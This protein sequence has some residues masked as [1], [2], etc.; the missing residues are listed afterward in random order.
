[1]VMGALGLAI[2]FFLV[3]Y[4]FSHRVLIISPIFEGLCR[5]FL[6][7]LGA[8]F[9]RPGLMGWPIWCGLALGM[10]VAGAGYLDQGNL[11]QRRY[12]PVLLVAM[13]VFLALV[14]DVGP[15][16]ESGLLLSGLVV[17]WVSKCLRPVLW[18]SE[19]TQTHNAEELYAGIVLVDWLAACPAAS[20]MGSFNQVSRQISLAFIALFVLAVLFQ[21]VT[22]EQ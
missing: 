2:V 1:M 6:Y 11:R 18:P 19:P 13:P 7:I 10:F 15:F 3:L 22:R 12:W 4:Y 21:R 9:A 14:M 17:L 16:R 20:F 5:F 8:T